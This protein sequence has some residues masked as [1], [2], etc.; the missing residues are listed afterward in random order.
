MPRLSQMSCAKS[1][2]F[3]GHMRHRTAAS[4]AVTGKMIFYSY[5]AVIAS[6]GAGTVDSSSM[7]PTLTQAL[8]HPQSIG[9]NTEG[10]VI[11]GLPIILI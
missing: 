2:L 4:G 8:S 3:S 1:S 11:R 6:D 5:S 7:E 10:R 9:R